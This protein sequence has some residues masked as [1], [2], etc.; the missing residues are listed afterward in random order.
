MCQTNARK[1]LEG[2]CKLLFCG[3]NIGNNSVCNWK[4]MNVHGDKKS[5][6]IAHGKYM[7]A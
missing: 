1:L 5:T 6:E 3:N 2:S 7:K 4:N